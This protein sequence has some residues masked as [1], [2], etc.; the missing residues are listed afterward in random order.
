[1]PQM[2]IITTTFRNETNAVV[3]EKI[4]L[5]VNNVYIKIIVTIFQTEINA[6]VQYA[7][8]A[9]IA[10]DK[11]RTGVDLKI[12]SDLVFFLLRTHK[13][14]QK[15]N[16]WYLRIIDQFSHSNW[17]ITFVAAAATVAFE[18]EHVICR[19]EYNSN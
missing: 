13:T 6:R 16:M 3:C 14:K 9:R 2:C 7:D 10:V 11:W 4:R 5:N 15:E 18:K 1:M 19:P 12:N 8:E 17:F